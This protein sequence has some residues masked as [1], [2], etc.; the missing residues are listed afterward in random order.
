LPD[1]D[2]RVTLPAAPDRQEG[3]A[4]GRADR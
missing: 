2:R 3:G 4:N 1:R